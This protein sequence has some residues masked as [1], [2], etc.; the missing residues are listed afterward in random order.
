MRGAMNGRRHSGGRGRKVRTMAALLAGP[1]LALQP[2]GCDEG[3]LREFRSASAGSVQSGV[4]SIVTGFIDGFFALYEA[5]ANAN[6]N[7]SAN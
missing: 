6:S 4:T 1:L 3:L 7:T 2:P 5:D